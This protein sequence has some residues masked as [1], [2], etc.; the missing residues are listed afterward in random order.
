M[1]TIVR[2]PVQQT[3]QKQG[4]GFV[5]DEQPAEKSRLT[6]TLQPNPTT[7]GKRN[8]LLQRK[9]C[10]DGFKH[11]VVGLPRLPSVQPHFA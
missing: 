11:E 3:L 4:F 1:T 9:K 7:S 10:G 2:S 6:R 8:V 5:P